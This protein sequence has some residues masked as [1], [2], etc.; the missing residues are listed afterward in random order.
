LSCFDFGTVHL[1]FNGFPSNKIKIKLP[2][3]WFLQA[4]Q[5]F[6]LTRHYAGGHIGMSLFTPCNIRVEHVV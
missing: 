2:K 1:N 5:M 4:E 3:L 6:W